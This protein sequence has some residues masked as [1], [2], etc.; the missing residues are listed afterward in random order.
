MQGS[1]DASARRI[2]RRLSL[3]AMRSALAIAIWPTDREVFPK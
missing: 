1:N 3:A 2:A